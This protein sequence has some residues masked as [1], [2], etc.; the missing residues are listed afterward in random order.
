MTVLRVPA[1]SS[2]RDGPSLGPQVASWM[3]HFLV[4]GPGDVRG[5]PYRL[6][7]EKRKVLFGIYALQ[8]D[9][10]R[11]FKRAGVS[12]RKGWA[13][14]ELAAAVTAAELH[15]WA[16]V[17]FSHW[18]EEDEFAQYGDWVYHYRPGEPVGIGVSDPY[19]PMVAYTE[20]QSEELA[21]GALCV[22]LGEGPLAADFDIGLERVLVLDDAG[23]P[24]GKAVALATSPDSR[25]GARTSF[26]VF[27]ETHRLV[28]PRSKQA[29]QTMMAN[30]P[31]RKKADPW[32]LEI[33]TSYEPGELSVAEG[34]MEYARLVRTGKVPDSR[35]FFYHRQAGDGHDLTTTDGLR[36]A[37][38]EACGDTAAWTDV[39]GIVEL[40][41]DPQ[42]D[43]SYWERVWLNRPVTAES[44]VFP[45]DFIDQVAHR[46]WKPPLGDT[47]T[48][49]FDGSITRDA[50]ALVGTHIETARQFLIALWECPLDA[51]GRPDADWQVPEDKV[52]QAVAEVYRRW[53]V[54]RMYADPY[55][56]NDHVAKWVGQ[57]TVK[58]G[59]D[60]GKPSVFA[61]PTN[62]F[63]KM[64]LSVKAYQHSMQHGEWSYDGHEKFRAHLANARRHP[65]EVYDEDGKQLYV[66]RK[67]RPDSLFKI[68]AAMAGCLSWEAY[69]DAVASG[70]NLQKRSKTLVAF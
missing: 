42:T 41:L 27:D 65:I 43:R 63:K 54:W 3:E 24:R 64:A 51:R 68:D 55:Y 47:I 19:V 59:K 12:V 13:K 6:D 4:H 67:E 53:N 29:H 11:R 10:R 34:T 49:G 44:Q 28:L 38:L 32:S 39:D 31:K 46:G 23:K 60:R 20:E 50:T 17:R 45:V 61:W 18:A 36:N 58:R 15:P 35:L 30:L 66:M 52:D 22:M 1:L 25:D 26:Q 21:Y 8:G 33:T 70:V 62:T 16:P 14:T 9:G 40:A 2:Y 5:Q 69:R 57:Y 48:V 56:W 7:D 37:V